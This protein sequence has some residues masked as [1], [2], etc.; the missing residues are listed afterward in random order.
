MQI[1]RSRMRQMALML[2]VSVAVL[3]SGC[4][5][6]IQTG[7]WIYLIISTC[8]SLVINGYTASLMKLGRRGS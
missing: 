3:E 8:V 1:R 6:T 7:E 4:N 5:A 2:F